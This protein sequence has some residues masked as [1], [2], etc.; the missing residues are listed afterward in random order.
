MKKKKMKK[1]FELITI[2]R[3]YI[4]KPDDDYFVKMNPATLEKVQILAK[5]IQK[6]IN[7]GEMT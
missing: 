5:I 6:K 3:L 1:A 7:L 4:E 2:A